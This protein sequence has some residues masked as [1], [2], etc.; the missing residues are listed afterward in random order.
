MTLLR[1]HIAMRIQ[2]EATQKRIA[3]KKPSK[4]LRWIK[5]IFD[6]QKKRRMKWKSN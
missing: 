4:L 1:E 6:R 5:T 2:R 3:N